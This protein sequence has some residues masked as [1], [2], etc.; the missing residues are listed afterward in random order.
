MSYQRDQT[1][2]PIHTVCAFSRVRRGLIAVVRVDQAA[3]C[4]VCQRP[5]WQVGKARQGLLLYRVVF[6]AADGDP[7]FE[8]Y[9]TR[10]CSEAD[11][12]IGPPVSLEVLPAWTVDSGQCRRYSSPS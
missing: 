12:C 10:C 7:A 6:V 5:R 1:T 4:Q 2:C 9:R 8:T 11:C 3:V